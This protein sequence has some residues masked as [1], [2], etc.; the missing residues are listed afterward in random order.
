MA[1]LQDLYPDDYA[2]CH[3]C[4]RLNT[5]GLHVK[6]AWHDGEATSRFLPLPHHLSMPGFVYGGLLASVIDCH[7][8]AAAAGASMVKAGEEPGR[9]ATHRFVTASLLV[10]FLKP[11]PM[12]VELLLRARPAEVGERKVVV[13]VSVLAGDA[14]CVR[15]RVTAV[16]LP[17][18]M[19]ARGD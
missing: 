15:G 13:N 19:T 8:M 6:S 5:H 14:E 3:G 11:T 18:H 10:E 9:D 7:A 1:F 17:A 2:H 16:R 12:G 4:G